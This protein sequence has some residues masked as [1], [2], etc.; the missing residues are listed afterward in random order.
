M[1]S[2]GG[3]GGV[4]EIIVRLWKTRT[5]PSE[6]RKGGTVIKVLLGRRKMLL[7]LRLSFAEIAR[8]RSQNLAGGPL[9]F[10]E[11]RVREKTAFTGNI[12][13]LAQKGFCPE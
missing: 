3:G 12:D 8:K 13:P 11:N 4:N 5:R 10:E 2:S 6:V 9:S 1:E 7:D